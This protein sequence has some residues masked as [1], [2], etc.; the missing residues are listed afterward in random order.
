MTSSRIV[1]AG[2]MAAAG[3]LAALPAA[4]QTAP[5]QPPAAAAPPAAPPPPAPP[6]AAAPPAPYEEAFQKAANDLL[7][8][9]AADVP[10]DKVQIVIDPLIDGVTGSQSVQTR[11]MER[12]LADLVKSKY[13]KFD[14]VAF[15]DDNLVK[16]PLILIGTFTAISAA[17]Q[18]TGPRDAYRICLALAD[19]KTRTLV[20]KGFARARPQGINATPAPFFND[21]PVWIKDDAIEAYVKSCQGTKAGDPLSP[22]YADRIDVAAV[23][24]QAINAYDTKKYK[25]ALQLYLKASTMPGGNQLRVWNGLSLTNLRLGKQEEAAYAFGQLVDLGLKGDRIAVQL[26]FAKSQANFVRN[27][28]I[29]GPYAMWLKTIAER[30]ATRP[31][32]CLEVVG[33]ASP[34]GSEEYNDKLSRS[35]ADYVKGRLEAGAADMKDRI[36]A[37]GMGFRENLIG[38]GKDDVTDALDRRVEFKVGR[39]GV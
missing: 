17:G 37:T 35:R 1:A 24:A 36:K 12:R 39:C 25:E 10:G 13:P 30:A 21:S 15:T 38:T 14:V 7:T 28:A 19:L 8:K 3:L 4:A 18:A 29:S 11:S 5:A 2:L 20:A 31:G 33:H 9:A 22:A 27:P 23:V 6:P 16:R 26:L 34:T 32:T